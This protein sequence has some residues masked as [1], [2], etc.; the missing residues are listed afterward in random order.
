MFVA[1]KGSLALLF[2]MVS[3]RLNDGLASTGRATALGAFSMLYQ[4]TKAPLVLAAGVVAGGLGPTAA[5]AVLGGTFLVAA[6]VAWLL[7]GPTTTG[8]V[9]T[10]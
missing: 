8:S 10:A 4:L 5:T 3:G 2:P 7:G 6:A 9:E 1:L